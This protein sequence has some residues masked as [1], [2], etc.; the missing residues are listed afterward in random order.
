M[1]KQI[2]NKIRQIVIK[3]EI[4]LKKLNKANQPKI[5][6]II[7]TKNIQIITLVINQR[8]PKK[9]RQNEKRQVSQ[10]QKKQI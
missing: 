5:Q 1:A 9:T 3:L 6:K 7:T 8:C 2:N 4:K 10:G